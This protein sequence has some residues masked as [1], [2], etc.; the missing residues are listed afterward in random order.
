MPASEPH[1]PYR[2]SSPKA[3]ASSDRGRKPAVAES[4]TGRQGRKRG[5][6]AVQKETHTAR[7]ADSTVASEQGGSPAPAGVEHA[8]SVAS[9]RP[10][11]G[12]NDFHASAVFDALNPAEKVADPEVSSQAGTWAEPIPFS[13]GSPTDLIDA[14]SVDGSPSNGVPIIERGGF[15]TK[16]PPSSPSTR[17]SR[18]V[19]YSAGI[20]PQQPHQALLE[21]S[22]RIPRQSFGASSPPPP[23][24]PQAHFYGLPEID[25]GLR[26]RLRETQDDCAANFLSFTKIPSPI[27]RRQKRRPDI[28]ML[29]FEDRLDVVAVEKDK[30]SAIGAL[31]GVGGTVVDAKVLTWESGVDPFLEIRPL[32]SLIVHGPRRHA[33]TSQAKSDSASEND[34]KPP[35]LNAG[36]QSHGRA[37]ES[38]EFQTTVEI[39]SLATLEH[40]TTLM[41]SHLTPGLPN[42]RGLPMSA[43]QP[44][45]NLKLDAKGN[46]LTVSSG[47]S[48]EVFVFMADNNSSAKFRCV[49]KFWTSIQ[50]LNDRRYSE[51]SSSTDADASPA[52]ANRGVNSSQPPIMSLSSR[53]LATV[54]PGSVSC[55]PLSI[56]VAQSSIVTIVPGLESRN[57]PP[58]PPVSCAL[59]SPDAETLLNRVA[60]G[61]AQEVVRGARWLGG[62]GLQTWN[63]YW[64]R[65]QHIN[66]HSSAHNRNLSHGDQNLPAA[67]F[68]P[69][70]APE[71]RPTSAEP[72]VVSI[73]D[74]QVL[75][76][77]SYASSSETVAPLATFQP[78]N[79]V[80]FLSFAP[81]GLAIV[82]STKKGD[83]QYVWDLKQINHLRAGVLSTISDSE[84]SARSGK[85]TQLSR[86]ARLTPSSIIDIEWK[87]PSGDRFAVITKNGTIHM[88]DMP[89]S[90]YQWPPIRRHTRVET[91]SA[92]ASPAVKAQSDETSV[93]GGVFGS[94]MKFAGK[95]QPILANLRGRALTVGMSNAVGNGNNSIG[96]ASATSIR[97][98]KAVA[99][100]LSRSVGAAAGTVNSL[101][102][103][104]DNRLHLDSLA[105]HPARS[106]VCWSQHREQPAL[107]VIDDQYIKSFSVSKRRG[108]SKPRRQPFSVI[109]A[110]PI[111]K[112]ALPALEQLSAVK[113]PSRRVSHHE[114]GGGEEPI[115]G[116]WMWEVPSRTVQTPR[117]VHPLSYAEIETNAPY[118][119]FHSDRRV[120]LFVYNDA[121]TE[122]IMIDAHEPWVFGNDISTTR[123]DIRAPVHSD[124]EEQKVGESVLYRH[125]SMTS[126][127]PTGNDHSMANQIVV[128]TRRRK[129][130][131]PHQSMLAPGAKLDEEDGF[132]EDD[133]DVLDFAEDR[134]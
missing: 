116:Y 96:F 73:I 51:S 121:S 68:P 44:V 117:I 109:D 1:N 111:V 18:P 13:K 130:K 113:G 133:C 55:Q 87:F 105:R 81:D 69:T 25:L 29:G 64:N 123:L 3:E 58:R 132:F 66:A 6:H 7:E 80:S 20:S 107:L 54:P 86:F 77:Q 49:G 71:S 74:L 16:T 34:Q 92:P 83:I 100:G 78:P 39:Y 2:T 38:I 15:S 46:F 124:E 48:G 24:L 82:S 114:I 103:A 104:G 41:W 134:V 8:A 126:G 122:D 62:Q 119:P 4:G 50:T 28:L 95:T 60:R 57:A 45:G 26:N 110:S 75:V 128:T 10:I 102:H 56:T 88:F 70:H 63:N 27:G 19:S 72:Q 9:S 76:A 97:G 120:N 43:P 14:I 23:H 12:R 33:H 65:D 11:P 52:D 131:T 84:A 40:V 112:V 125:T 115:A 127:E 37:N 59:E 108:S 22:S 118:Q 99:A 36:G 106:R 67:F 35:G 17:Q 5:K 47:T 91:S 30:L 32:V 31:S 93:V 90:A 89:L 42:I 94:A 85:V 98:S 79:G 53:W 129:N 21:R 61:V 101:R